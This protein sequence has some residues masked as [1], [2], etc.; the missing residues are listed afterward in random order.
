MDTHYNIHA[1]ACK[2]VYGKGK[3]KKEREKNGKR[4]QE[5]GKDTEMEKAWVLGL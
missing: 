4:T 1:R 3:G 2:R 5:R